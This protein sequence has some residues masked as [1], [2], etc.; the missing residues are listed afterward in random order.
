M[1]SPHKVF[2]KFNNFNNASPILL[3]NFSILLSLSF[4]L[5]I[6]TPTPLALISVSH[7]RIKGITYFLIFLSIVFVISTK[8]FGEILIFWTYLLS[9]VIATAISE[10]IIR[11]IHPIRGLIITSGIFLLVLS[12]I[13]GMWSLSIQGNLKDHITKKVEHISTEFKKNEKKYFSQKN[14]D[15]R[16]TAIVLSKPELLAEEIIKTIPLTIV[17]G[18]IFTLWTNIALLLRYLSIRNNNGTNNSYCYSIKDLFYFKVPEYFIWPLIILLGFMLSGS[19]IHQNIGIIAKNLLFCLGL[20]YF[21]QGFGILIELFDLLKLEGFFRSLLI[22]LT[23]ITSYWILALIGL[24]DL[25]VDFRAFL[26]KKFKERNK[27]EDEEEEEEEEENKEEDDGD[28]EKKKEK[29]H[30]ESR[31]YNYDKK[32]EQNSSDNNKKDDIEKK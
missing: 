20:F 17:I 19:H 8:I 16:E 30:K 29:E 22:V 6:F 1:T 18:L 27:E 28:E 32:K 10:I 21:F 15:S 12:L 9:V 2:Y 3:G 26:N 25:W 4:I 24:F 5:S 13:V 11:N 31:E 23:V 14:K 7:G